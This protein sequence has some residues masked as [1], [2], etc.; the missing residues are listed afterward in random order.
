MN[1]KLQGID[2]IATESIV[3]GWLKKLGVFFKG[4]VNDGQIVF[5][6]EANKMGKKKQSVG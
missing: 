1:G 5:N 6:C 4:R 3:A 2:G